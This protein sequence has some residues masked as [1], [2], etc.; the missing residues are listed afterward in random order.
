MRVDSLIREIK[1]LEKDKNWY[2]HQYLR[3]KFK[4]S[5]TEEILEWYQLTFGEKI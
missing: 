1:K 5:D 2:K 4:L 3:C